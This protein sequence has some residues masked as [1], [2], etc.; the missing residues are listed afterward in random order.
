MVPTSF[1]DGVPLEVLHSCTTSGLVVFV[2]AEFTPKDKKEQGG[3]QSDSRKSLSCH[4]QK[5]VD[6]VYLLAGS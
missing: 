5:L 2:N 3:S 1:A 6:Y 4:F